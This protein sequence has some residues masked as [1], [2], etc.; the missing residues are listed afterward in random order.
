MV[1]DRAVLGDADRRRPHVRDATAP[2]PSSAAA[3]ATAA[4]GGATGRHEER[5]G[6][7]APQLEAFGS[8]HSDLDRSRSLLQKPDLDL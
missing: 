7:R 4:A 8:S 1:V 2:A 6:C 3:A 5:V